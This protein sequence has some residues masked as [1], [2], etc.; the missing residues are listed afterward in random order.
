MLTSRLIKLVEVCT[1]TNLNIHVN[2]K[3]KTCNFLY[4]YG[5][6]IAL[7]YMFLAGEIIFDR[8]YGESKGYGFV[9]SSYE[10]AARMGLKEMDGL[11]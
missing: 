3:T 9:R 6:F 2:Q 8:V 4:L 7:L 10:A 5:N 11:A 1:Q